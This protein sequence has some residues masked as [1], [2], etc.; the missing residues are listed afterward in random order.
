MRQPYDWRENPRTGKCMNHLLAALS[1]I[2]WLVVALAV[3]LCFRT[4][5]L[6]YRWLWAVACVLGVA[7]VFLDQAGDSVRVTAV[8][9]GLLRP[10]LLSASLSATT[11]PTVVVPVVAL[12]FILWRQVRRRRGDA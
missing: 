3:V 11:A 6:R 5:A 10:E 2:A 4:P 8:S 1:G 12:V 9:L 7:Q